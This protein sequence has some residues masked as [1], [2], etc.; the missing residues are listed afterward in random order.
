MFFKIGVL[1]SFAN[2]TKFNKLFLPFLPFDHI[3]LDDQR[4]LNKV[5]IVQKFK[6]TL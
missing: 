3:T 1:E 5:V 6:L 4:V 2:F